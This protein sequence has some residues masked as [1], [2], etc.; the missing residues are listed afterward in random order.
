[1]SLN[2]RVLVDAAGRTILGEHE[3]ETK[4]VITLRNPATLFIQPNQ[5]TGQLA[6]QLIPFFFREFVIE[7]QRAVGLAWSFDKK[8][9]SYTDEFKLD[10][11]LSD[12]YEKMMTKEANTNPPLVE[13]L[14]GAVKNTAKEVKLFE[15][16]ETIP[17]E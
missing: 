2:L 16:A 6:V 3:K 11:R 17:A 9:I 4:D 1:M 15:E 8:S 7:E 10:A 5:Q 12:Q 13:D 14:G